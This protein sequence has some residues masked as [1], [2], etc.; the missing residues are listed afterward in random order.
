MQPKN[1]SQRIADLRFRSRHAVS[2]AGFVGTLSARQPGAEH[3][4]VLYCGAQG[5][6]GELVHAARAPIGSLDAV[7]RAFLIPALHVRVEADRS[8]LSPS[9]NDSLVP[10]VRQ[11]MQ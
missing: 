9:G 5:M 6:Q 10:S 3:P 11:A 8:V 7:L 4:S 2:R 1:S